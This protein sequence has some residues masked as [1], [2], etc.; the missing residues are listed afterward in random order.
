[1]IMKIRAHMIMLR[2]L[3]CLRAKN[4]VLLLF[5]YRFGRHTFRSRLPNFK[6]LPTPFLVGFNIFQELHTSGN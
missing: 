1:M 3:H 4:D 5:M 2:R 6:I